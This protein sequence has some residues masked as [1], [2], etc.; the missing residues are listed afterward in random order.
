MSLWW[1][2]GIACSMALSSGVIFFC[3]R[4]MQQRISDQQERALQLEQRLAS[5]QAELAEKN[6]PKPPP[7]R[8]KKKDEH[9]LEM[10]N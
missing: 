10:F 7:I 4:R 1:Y 6:I 9:Q 8:S 2:L 3:Y 5:L